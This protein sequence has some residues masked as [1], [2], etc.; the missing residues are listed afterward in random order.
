MREFRL[1]VLFLLLM[2]GGGLSLS[3]Q[4]RVISGKVFDA[5]QQPMVGVTVQIEGTTRG[6]ISSADGSFELEVPAEEVILNVSF[7]GF[8]S[9]KVN[10]PPTQTH[11]TIN[12]ME[13]VFL[14]DE[15]VVVGYG[16]QKRV[17]LTG[18]VAV[19]GGK[20]LEDRVAH[21]VTHMLQGSVAG[22]NI[23]TSSGRPG[24]TPSINVRGVT[25]INGAEPL[26]LIDG[27]PGDLDRINPNDVESIS[28][29]KDAAAAAVYGARAAFG[30]ILVT[31]KS[32]TARDGKALVRYSSRFG[33]EESTTSTD[34]EDRGYWSV[35]TVN[36]FWEADSGTKYFN[37]TDKDMQQLLARVNDK[38]EHP[39]RPWVI[40]DVRNGRN[41]W[42]Y[43]G[44]YD[45]WDMM[46]RS[47]QPVQKHN[48]SLSGGS[49]D[50]KYLVSG[51]LDK[52][53]G[54]QKQHPD[55]FEKYNLRSKNDFNINKITKFSNNTS[56]YT[57]K[58]TSIGD[59]S[60]DNTLG[61][62]GRHAL[63]NIPMKNP[64]GSWVYGTP[65]SSYKVGNG[66]HIM[67]G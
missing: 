10:I 60:I 34:Y 41:Q 65:Y 47:K 64:D 13:D 53:E 3:A 5:E 45:W 4:N 24:S 30:V 1:L 67:V 7:M 43:Y 52:Q 58:Y 49:K 6:T 28:V 29:I 33:W 16:K 36:K 59:G 55:I 19:V 8:V 18:S 56:F 57:S 66:R 15:T 12:L 31:T 51:A 2:L 61:Y 20:E 23:T 54:I 39:D 11:V 14:L 17:N 35:Y 37:Y 21:S 40:E 42:V 63:A 50:I 25:S 32:G 46:Y 26:V 44:N 38:E 62:S 27:T 22:L 48:V 9:Q